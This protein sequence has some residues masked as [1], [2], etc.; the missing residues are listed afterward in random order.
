MKPPQN[1]KTAFCTR[2]EYPQEKFEKHIFWNAIHP[3]MK[4][5]AFLI[6]RFRPDFFRNDLDFIRSL[7]TA[8]TKQEVRIIVNSLHFDPTFERG[9]LRGFLRVRISR[10][11][12]TRIAGE[13]LMSDRS[14]TLTRSSH[15]TPA[16]QKNPARV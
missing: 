9:F 14:R 5:L 7:A 4:P 13:V 6:D 3:E 12:L 16:A 15:F 2:F 8:E 10:R 1:F 11:R